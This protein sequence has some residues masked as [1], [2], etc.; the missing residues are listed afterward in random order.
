VRKKRKTYYIEED[1]ILQVKAYAHKLNISENDAF[2]QAVDAYTKLVYNKEE[3]FTL[4]IDHKPL[5]LEAVDNLIYQTKR[6]LDTALP[7][8]NSRETIEQN[9]QTRLTYLQSI[10][11]NLIDKKKP[12]KR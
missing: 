9:L 11:K 6:I 4:P 1:T 10:R 2:E 8:D 5:L 7:N 3:F 12:T